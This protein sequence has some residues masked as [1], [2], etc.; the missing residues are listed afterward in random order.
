MIYA[1]V[2][3]AGINGLYATIDLIYDVSTTTWTVSPAQE[4]VVLFQV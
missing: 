2:Y 3:A 1:V 4:T